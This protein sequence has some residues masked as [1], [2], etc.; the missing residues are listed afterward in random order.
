VAKSKSGTPGDVKTKRITKRNNGKYI[1]PH[2]KWIAS[3]TK[4][5]E[6]NLREGGRISRMADFLRKVLPDHT[7]ERQPKNAVQVS[8]TPIEIPLEVTPKRES[9]NDDAEAIDL[10]VG[11]NTSFPG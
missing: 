9:S 2:D 5:R 6:A 10:R 3:R 7:V 11:Q 4:M 1:H 8:D